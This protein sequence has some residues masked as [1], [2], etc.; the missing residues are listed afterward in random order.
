MTNR[1]VRTLAW[2]ALGVGFMF[3]SGCSRSEQ[4][5]S[6]SVEASSTAPSSYATAGQKAEPKS[7]EAQSVEPQVQSEVESMEAQKRA[8]L[9]GTLGLRSTRRALR[10]RRWTKATSRLRYRHWNK[11]AGS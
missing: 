10:S 6:T 5:K 9:L 1:D 11:P 2:M 8:S 7:P 3:A 4:G